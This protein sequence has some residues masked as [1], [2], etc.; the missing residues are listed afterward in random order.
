[1]YRLLGCGLLFLTCF[2]AGR[3]GAA[4]LRRERETLAELIAA[5]E[6][7]AGELAFAAPP[8]GALCR[9]AGE[10]RSPSVRAFFEA[11]AAE[12][13]QPDLA[14]EGLTRRACGR[15]K[16][17][18]PAS[19]TAA[20]ARLFDSFGRRDRDGQLAQLRLV[21]LELEQAN[22]VLSGELDARC[23]V[24]EALGLAAGTALVVLVV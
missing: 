10:G 19:S 13:A 5:L 11:L 6:T 15:A 16:L 8:F 12:A 21:I 7:V 1:M 18:L 24:M 2:W 4:G 22:G 9:R 14:T 3:R 23:R 17:G 20:L